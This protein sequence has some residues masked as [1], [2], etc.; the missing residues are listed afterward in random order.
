MSALAD[1][2]NISILLAVVI[3][4]SGYLLGNTDDVITSDAIDAIKTDIAEI[5]QAQ[6]DFQTALHDHEAKGAHSAADKDIEHL[7]KLVDKLDDRVRNIELF[8]TKKLQ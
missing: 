4:G 3:S 5:K 1:K 6:R 2:S 8:G 7:S